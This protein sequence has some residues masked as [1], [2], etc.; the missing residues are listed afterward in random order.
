MATCA[1]ELLEAWRWREDALFETDGTFE[2]GAEK[3]GLFEIGTF[4][5]GAFQVGLLELGAEKVGPFEVGIFEVGAAQIF[6]VVAPR[7]RQRRMATA[8]EAIVVVW[9]EL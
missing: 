7:S 6:H 4:E 9:P 2:F 8:N 1:L 5:V 3:P